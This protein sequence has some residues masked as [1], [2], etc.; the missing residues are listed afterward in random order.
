MAPLPILVGVKFNMV[1]FQV[2]HLVIVFLTSSEDTRLHWLISFHQ[3][4]TNR[5][6]LL[7]PGQVPDFVFHARIREF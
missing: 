7:C 5:Q 3:V 2:L 6:S 1:A 4:E